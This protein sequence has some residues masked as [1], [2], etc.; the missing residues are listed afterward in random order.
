MFEL[1]VYYYLIDFDDTSTHVEGTV[2]AEDE[3]HAIDTLNDWYYGHSF[4]DIEL[5]F[6]SMLELVREEKREEGN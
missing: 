3:E 2:I 4:S 6:V 1:S 5:E